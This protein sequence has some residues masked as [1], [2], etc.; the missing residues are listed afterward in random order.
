M[1]PNEVEGTRAVRATGKVRP[2]VP[3]IFN[4]D[5]R[6]RTIGGEQKRHRNFGDE[7]VVSHGLERWELPVRQ[8]GEQSLER[9]R[10]IRHGALVT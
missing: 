8:P 4:G 1:L 10:A 5:P 6:R 3:R 9:Y 7:A 2:R